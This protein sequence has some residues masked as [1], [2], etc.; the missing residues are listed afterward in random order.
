M[1]TKK[2]DNPVND[3]ELLH[4]GDDM[5]GIQV[6]VDDPSFGSLYPTIQW[7]NGDPT[8]KQAGN[9]AHT[10]GFFIPA[11]AGIEVPGAEE[12]TLITSEGEEIP[13][14]AIRDLTGSPIRW[15]R[16]W[17]TLPEES[18]GL[19]LVWANDM[20]EDAKQHALA[21]GYSRPRGR[22]QLLFLIDGMSEPVLLSFGGTAS[23]AVFSSG[24]GKGR[25][26][27]PSYGQLIVNRARTLARRVGKNINYPMC[28]FK[29]TLGPDRDEKSEP[30]FTKVGTGSNTSKVTMP[31]WI[32]RPVGSP[33][34]AE[35]RRLYVGNER[36]TLLQDIHKEADEWVAQWGHDALVVRL[37]KLLNR[38]PLDLGTTTATAAPEGALPD[39]QSTPF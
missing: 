20:Y 4:G 5:F 32:D 22:G 23:Q 30:V 36:F 39:E 8:K 13:G 28:A 29:L 17:R 21:N 14:F 15:R 6:E 9:I 7:V 25:G 10:G 16:C 27:L 24:S 37:K 1:A 26:I 33:S 11:E 12:Y 19:A 31:V 34:E 38:E 3:A 35:I 18:G 2:T